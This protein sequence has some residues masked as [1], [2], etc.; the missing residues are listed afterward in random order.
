MLEEKFSVTVSKG[1]LEGKFDLCICSVDTT[2]VPAK[3]G[4]GVVGFDGY[5]GIKG[6]KAS[7]AAMKEGLNPF[8]LCGFRLILMTQSFTLLPLKE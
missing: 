3:K 1:Y 7:F 6:T 4:G 2:T 8:L 5:D